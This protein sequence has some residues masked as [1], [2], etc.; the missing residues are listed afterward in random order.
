MI[1]LDFADLRTTIQEAGLALMETGVGTGENR[2]RD[3]S[4]KAISSPLLEDVSLDSAK[5][6]LYNII[7]FRD[8]TIAEVN[9]IGSMIRD[10]APED[11][12]IIFGNVDCNG[13]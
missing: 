8:I 11:C 7:V 5:A 3:V 6:I 12:N 9:E 10:A 13:H 4:Q 2:A 1:N